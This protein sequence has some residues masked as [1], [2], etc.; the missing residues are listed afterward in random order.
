MTDLTPTIQAKSDQLNSDDLMAG[1]ITIKITQVVFGGGEDQ[2]INIRYEGDNGKPWKP[3][4]SMRRVLVSVWG[5]DGSNYVGKSLTLWRDPSVKW[6]G[7]EVGGIRISHMSG[8]DKNISMSLTATRG[9]KKPFTVK[10]LVIQDTG[11]PITEQDYKGWTDRM[12]KAD[13][14]EA[15]EKIRDQIKAVSDR[16]DED[17]RAKL[18][19]YYTDRLSQIKGQSAV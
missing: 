1:P 19:K 3:C 8:I 17:S 10:P 2:P 18:R 9:S 11:A 4:K 5:P 13:T 14:L 6:A 7:V 12:D 16:Y 15:I